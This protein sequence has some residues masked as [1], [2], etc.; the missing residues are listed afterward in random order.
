MA[1]IGFGLSGAFHRKF[2][3]RNFV[4]PC[5]MISGSNLSFSCKCHKTVETKGD[6]K[7]LFWGDTNWARNTKN[8]QKISFSKGFNKKFHSFE[9]TQ[10]N[11]F[12]LQHIYFSYTY[13]SWKQN[14]FSDFLFHFSYILSLDNILW[15]SYISFK[16]RIFVAH[17]LNILLCW[18][19]TSAVQASW[20]PQTLLDVNR[21]KSLR[22][23]IQRRFLR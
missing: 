6:A 4:H 9:L 15:T 23:N 13:I 17:V 12:R 14:I 8:R 10:E 11:Q 7:F 3:N 20:T 18:K 19:L 5:I 1:G 16:F 22:T 2:G 21:I